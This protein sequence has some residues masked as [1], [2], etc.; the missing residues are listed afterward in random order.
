MR[1][2]GFFLAGAAIDFRE[3]DLIFFKLSKKSA[4]MYAELFCRGES[5]V[6]STL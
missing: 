2:A 3:G 1:L 5:V 6:V 4:L